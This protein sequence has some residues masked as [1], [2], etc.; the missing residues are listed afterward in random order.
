MS[1]T[2]YRAA[3]PREMSLNRQKRKADI[4]DAPDAVHIRAWSI[5]VRNTKMAAPRQFAGPAGAVRIPIWQQSI[6]LIAGERFCIDQD[7]NQ[8]RRLVAAVD[9]TVVGAAL[10]QDVEWPHRHFT[11]V[12]QVPLLR[13]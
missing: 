4:G 1:L 5:C 13:L 11:D 7:R 2:S 6:W 10:N 12:E 8:Q 3:P 9:P